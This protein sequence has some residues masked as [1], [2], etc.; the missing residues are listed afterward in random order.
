MWNVKNKT[1]NFNFDVFVIV[2]VNGFSLR[3]VRIKK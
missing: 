3:E 1:N 2:L